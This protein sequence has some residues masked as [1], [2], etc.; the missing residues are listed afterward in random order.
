MAEIIIGSRRDSVI[1][2]NQ[3]IAMFQFR[4]HVFYE[5]L[6]WEVPSINNME[7]DEF[8]EMDPVY[9]LSTPDRRSIDGCVRLMPTSGSYMLKDTFPQLLRGEEAPVSDDVW[10]YSRFA[11]ATDDKNDRS[12]VVVNEAT[13]GILMASVRFAFDHGIRE[14]VA[15][16][17]V[18]MERYIKNWV[19]MS[20]ERL[21]DGKAMYVGNTLSTACR[22]KMNQ[23]TYDS[24][25]LLSDQFDR[26]EA[27]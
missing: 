21:G 1:R 18:A 23:K 27:A 14:Y 19:G 25:Q 22:V 17:S 24:L 2:I 3:L 13:V 20:M 26:K 15:V 10:E 8:D 9:I 4:H 11:V 12:Q 5:K 7:I 16:I 6:G